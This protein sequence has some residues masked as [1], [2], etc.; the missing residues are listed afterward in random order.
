MRIIRYKH[1]ILLFILFI[2]NLGFGVKVFAQYSGS[3]FMLRDNFYAQMLNPSYMRSDDA[4]EI[5]VLGLAGLSFINSGNFKISDIITTEKPGIPE[6]DFKHF[7][8]TGNTNN[9]L[10]L[11]LSI[12]IVFVSI[13]LKRG[14]VSFFYRENVRAFSKFKMDMI[15]LLINGN[16][17]PEYK[18]VSSDE[19]NMFGVGYRDFTFGYARKLNEKIDLGVHTKIM[20]G[21]AFLAV[22]NWEY[23][24]ETSTLGDVVTLSSTGKG[25]LSVPA[26]L[27][28]SS[29]KHFF[30][31]EGKGIAGKYFGGFD[32]PGLA[33][34]LGGT[35]TMNDQNIFS[36][37]ILDLGGIWFRKGSWDLEQ[38][39]RV[40]FSGFDIANAVRYPDEAGTVLP[41]DLM[42]STKENIRDVYRPVADSAQFFQNLSPK[43][44]LHYHY[45][46]SEKL[47]MGITNQSTFIKNDF[48]N[49]FTLSAMQR[50]ANFLV[51][52]NLNLHGISDV[53]V[54]A[55]FQYEWKFGQV[56][57]A[58]DNL[59]AFYHPAN[60]KTFSITAGMC[61]LLNHEKNAKT[62]NARKKGTGKPK[63]K[64]STYLPFFLKRR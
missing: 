40:E 30:S 56:F 23:G 33:I 10:K 19:V 53:S 34:D 32:N 27:N 63:N 13:P 43:T 57:M 39:E 3:L 21:S 22:E 36:V 47:W 41:I 51:F 17:D 46:Y 7:Y 61:F 26:P 2:L 29:E 25:N 31:V 15:E 9:F 35:F 52:E 58:T 54:G 50:G 38:N 20:F 11:S 59:L 6:I 45:K 55:G 8:E 28:L 62:G 42:Q 16:T 49:T 1:I 44:I 5:A 24:I 37:S 60:N 12:P 64:I 14:V 4:T 48:W 18:N